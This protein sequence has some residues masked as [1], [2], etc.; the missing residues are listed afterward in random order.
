EK[1][2]N[3]LNLSVALISVASAGQVATSLAAKGGEPPGSFQ[4]RVE[5]RGGGEHLSATGQAAFEQSKIVARSESLQRIIK[6]AEKAGSP[7]GCRADCRGNR[8]GKRNDRAHHSPALTTQQPSL[9]R[10]ELRRHS[11]ASGRKRAFRLRKRRV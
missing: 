2:V 5:A 4:A 6:L 3:G 10:R 11:R 7:P 9:G 1:A 8:H